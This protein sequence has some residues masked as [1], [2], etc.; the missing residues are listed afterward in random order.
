VDYDDHIEFGWDEL[1]SEACF[2]GRKFD[3][4]FASKAFADPNRLVLPDLR[5]DYGEPRFELYGAIGDR[6]YVVVFTWRASKV[7]I[8][9]ARKAN[10]CEV[11]RYGNRSNEDRHEDAGD[12][13][14]WSHR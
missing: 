5:E 8:I 13:E 12:R 10:R 4:E 6:L 1:K 3:F 14:D 9:S 2:A 11:A 7:P